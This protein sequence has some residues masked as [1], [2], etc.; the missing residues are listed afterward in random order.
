MN[1]VSKFL[2][3]C[4]GADT[5]LLK[6]YP[7][8]ITKQSAVG[9]AV[10]FT[11]L[12]A[13]LSGGYAAYRIFDYPNEQLTPPSDTNTYIFVGILWGL[14]IFNL[15]RLIVLSVKKTGSR[16]QLFWTTFPRLIL[17][18]LISLVI[19][20]PLEIRIFQDRIADTL[21]D[22]RLE[23][24]LE[25]KKKIE[26]LTGLG[27]ALQEKEQ[28]DEAKKQAQKELSLD[29]DS[30]ECV[31]LRA[32]IPPAEAALSRSQ[33]I[34]NREYTGLVR[35]INFINNKD[36]RH[37]TFSYDENQKKVYTMIPSSRIELNKYTNRRSSIVG[38][39]NRKRDVVESLKSQLVAA[40][41]TF[42]KGKQTVF[43]AAQQQADEALRLAKRTQEIA[44]SLAA[45]KENDTNLGLSNN[46][47]A[48]LGALGE[49]TKWQVAEE[50]KKKP[51][52]TMFWINLALIILF[53]VIETAPILV[54]AIAPLSAY[55]YALD[56]KLQARREEI[57]KNKQTKQ[58]EHQMYMQKSA[59][60]YESDIQ[61]Y[62]Y[63]RSVAQSA[64]LDK[65]NEKVDEWRDDSSS[66]DFDALMN[67]ADKTKPKTGPGTE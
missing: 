44:D 47:V 14:L 21:S 24:Q 18:V 34:L 40:V 49:L 39:R 45:A 37:W 13:L 35:N 41:T 67:E 5:K 19:A 17:A 15:D 46:F 4:A 29:C 43:N 6:K 64:A 16:S 51:T 50:G 65:F 22:L 30:P 32:A 27:G 42:K 31:R 11:G 28:T 10:L 2:C 8:D 26:T 20:K 55:D 57:E 61:H 23:E 38:D 25:D 52:N 53:I 59:H 36:S 66:D 56:E 7:E 58:L 48:Q 63:T 54:K 33:G 9:L 1:F 3:W 60:D 62:I 12:F